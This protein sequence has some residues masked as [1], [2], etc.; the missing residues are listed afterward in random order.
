MTTETPDDPGPS[1]QPRIGRGTIMAAAAVGAALI[2]TAA[3]VVPWAVGSLEKSS[4]ADSLQVRSDPATGDGAVLADAAMADLPV[5]GAPYEFEMPDDYVPA[6]WRIPLDSPFETF[7]LAIGFSERGSAQ[8]SEEQES[9][10]REHAQVQDDWMTGVVLHNDASTGGAISLTNLRYVA[11]ARDAEP[12]IPFTCPVPAAGGPSGQGISL[13]VDGSPAVWGEDGY[14]EPVEVPG[15]PVTIN[16]E[17]GEILYSYLSETGGSA[18]DR[19]GDVIADLADGSGSVIVFENLRADRERVVGFEIGYL[20]DDP[21]NRLRCAMTD[22]AGPPPNFWIAY[23]HFTP[24]TPDEAADLLRA[25][26]AA[27]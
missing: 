22:E 24:C 19:I 25:A 23:D 9:W 20:P 7:P 4:D 3:I 8:C 1:A 11:E 10:L 18:V 14:G 16:L 21:E 5:V 6:H 2:A 27:S 17:P 15:S 12:W 26:A 13:P